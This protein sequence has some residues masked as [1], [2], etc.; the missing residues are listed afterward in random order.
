M[1]L[2]GTKPTGFTLM[3]LLVV[4]AIIAILAALLLPA[5]SRAKGS[6]RRVLC[7]NNEREIDVATRLYADD[8]ADVVSFYTN[9]I[10][11]AYKENI[12]PYLGANPNAA[13][14]HP[15]FICP[16]DDFDLDGPI[17]SW[18]T[19]HS[20]GRGFH[21]QAWTHFAS[22]WFNGGVRETNDFG[23]AQKPFTSVR[24]P[25]LTVL[26]A[27]ISGGIGVSGHVRIQPLQFPNAK[28]VLGFVDGHVSLTPVYW[29]GV[30]GSPGFP[31]YYEP[32]A[33]CDYKWTG[34]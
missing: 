25:A 16:A 26:G 17:G 11:F 14:N 4:I 28:N 13:T 12:L 6:A 27:E 30:V 24:L 15:V 32:P 9:E 10:Y 8:H 20:R 29:N 31:A 1:S 2:P 22:Y 34:T 18:F 19:Y 5:L 7:L 21:A 23:L 33:D 3:E